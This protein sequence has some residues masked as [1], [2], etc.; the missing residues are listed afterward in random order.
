MEIRR[1]SPSH[2]LKNLYSVDLSIYT[3]LE[4]IISTSR[5]SIKK[6]INLGPIHIL[7]TS[8]KFSDFFST[9]LKMAAIKKNKEHN[10][11]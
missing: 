7:T 6:I 11:I 3:L 4:R 8:L 1:P 9:L 10:I 5:G 2:G